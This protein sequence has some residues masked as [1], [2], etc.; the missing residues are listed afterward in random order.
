MIQALKSTMI[1]LEAIALSQV[2]SDHGK[3]PR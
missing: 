2:Q 3:E 1:A